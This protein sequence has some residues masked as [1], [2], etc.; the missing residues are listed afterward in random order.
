MMGANNISISLP[1]LHQADNILKFIICDTFVKYQQSAKSEKK[2]N[3]LFL[4]SQCNATIQF[5]PEV[6]HITKDDMPH[7][8]VQWQL[9]HG[10]FIRSDI[11]QMVIL[12]ISHSQPHTF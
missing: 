5:L 7:T 8:W 4:Y 2:I 1:K 12:I 6:R 11:Q 3:D 9:A 10:A